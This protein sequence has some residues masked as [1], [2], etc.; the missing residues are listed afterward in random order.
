MIKRFFVAF[1]ILLP[2]LL[3]FN[4][5]K[6]SL[7]QDGYR[8]ID[9]IFT[10]YESQWTDSLLR[11]MSTEEKI[12]QLFMIAAY[13]KLGFTHWKHIGD[14][15]EK[16]HIGG[17]IVMQGSPFQTARMINYLQSRSNI[18]LIVGIDAEWGLAMR[19]DSTIEFPYQ[20]A[21]GA[22]KDATLIYDMGKEIARECKRL[23]I[24]INFAPVVDINNNPQNPVIGIRS[25]GEDKYEV[26]RYGL[27]Y[28]QGLQ[29]NGIIAFAKH[30]PGHGDTDKDSHKTLPIIRA[31]TIRLDT[32]ELYPF[33]KLIHNG[34]FGVMVAHLYIPAIVHRKNLPSSLSSEVVDSLLRKKLHFKGLIITDAL[35]MKGVSDYFGS[36]Q[37]SVMALKA[38]CDILLMPQDLQK[39]FLGVKNALKTHELS[40]TNLNEKVRKI[41]NVKVWLGLHNGKNRYVSTKNLYQD[42]NTSEA[43]FLH[44][45]LIENALT[46]IKNEN[47]I[48]PFQHLDKIKIASVSIDNGKNTVF[49]DF[50]RRY[51]GVDNFAIKANSKAENYNSLLNKLKKY[52]YVI[53]GIH[54]IQKFGVKT[55]GIPISEVN[56]ISKLA[57]NS[58]VI[59][60]LFGNPYSLK[61]FKNLN[62]IPVI[63]IAYENSYDAQSLAAQLLFGG[64]EAKG[65]LPI[66]VAG[67]K[68]FTSI[69]TPK[70]RLKYSVPEE[71]NIDTTKLKKVDSIILGAIEQRAFP[72]CQ[73]VAVKDGI[74]FFQ[75]SYGYFTYDQLQPVKWYNL[76]DIASVTKV[77]A[78]TAALM[79]LYD[80][81]KFDPYKKLGDYLPETKGTNKY[82][83][84][85]L[86]I[87]THQARLH[88]WIPF[89]WQTIDW[90]WDMPKAQYYRFTKQKGFTVQV[91]KN[92]Y[93]KDDFY[94]EIYRRIYNSPLYR[95]KRYRYSDLGFYMFKKIIE[96][97]TGM[98]LD[99]FVTDSFYRPLGTWS[100]RY[101]P[102]R[103][104]PKKYIV[105]TELDTKFR[106]QLLQGY[107][108]DYGAALL[109][110]VG[111]HAGL[112]ANANDLA[113]F[114]QMLLRNGTYAGKKYLNPQTV[115]LFTTKPFK[116]NRR[117]LGFDSKRFGMRS[118]ACSYASEQSFGHLGFTGCMVWADPKYNFIY[119]FL[120]NRIYPSVKNRKIIDMNIR[121]NVQKFLYESFLVHYAH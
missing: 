30:F 4:I 25:F 72:G 53:V 110:G 16:Y 88:A 99:K 55:F 121:A 64:I 56:F 62:K 20:M 10:N 12:G 91:A 70:I 57:N 114:F 81:G 1:V 100:I 74:V 29:T 19:L 85:I 42:L 47:S 17:I 31:D 59:L 38:G 118:P 102:L 115:K 58:K 13:P 92:L 7:F 108:H 109:G 46:L 32:L 95:Y 18:P 37:A 39:A 77:V 94:R 3:S 117:A 79:K 84:R 106:H 98:S 90:N 14:L 111:G 48:I 104:Y 33:K 86:D 2:L 63:L 103:Y 68:L 93:L 83:L 119:V 50:L 35:S 26:A 41:L 120:S 82:N 44:R 67:F 71:L 89:Y 27:A 78:T 43:K 40:L 28:M 51:D 101:N 54:K 15:I 65:R 76:Y 9:P 21:L 61:R 8:D 96:N 34:V 45:K 69:H 112:F 49:Q 52:D 87:L 66:S 75:K 113:V 80:Q 24:H 11:V 5:D 73:V 36:G 60:V 105:P 6:V 22:V 107:V 116:R 23:G 97:Q